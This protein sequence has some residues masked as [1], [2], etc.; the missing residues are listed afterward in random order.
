MATK[1]VTVRLLSGPSVLKEGIV[2]GPPPPPLR[3]LSS[4]TISAEAIAKHPES[5][6]GQAIEA[7]GESADGI[8]EFSRKGGTTISVW[9]RK[10][11]LF[12]LAVQVHIAGSLEGLNVAP[13]GFT[14][15]EVVEELHGY[16]NLP[17]QLAQLRAALVP[18]TAHHMRLLA[19]DAAAQIWQ[20]MQGDV[21]G[22]LASNPTALLG[23]G[24]AVFALEHMGPLQLAAATVSLVSIQDAYLVARITQQWE[25]AAKEG[26]LELDWDKPK[27]TG[28][29]AL[30][31]V[32]HWPGVGVDQW[33]G[34]T[35]IPWLELE[36]LFTEVASPL[37]GSVWGQLKRL[38]AEAAGYG[39][40]AVTLTLRR[41]QLPKR[42]RRELGLSLEDE[43]GWQKWGEADADDDWEGEYDSEDERCMGYA[44]VYTERYTRPAW[45]EEEE[46]QEEPR[47][48]YA[49]ALRRVLPLIVLTF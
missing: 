13:D 27:G 31:P 33:N 49:K 23:P 48:R 6:L 17:Y 32:V 42:E 20:K 4:C 22:M 11:A 16:W 41:T 46:E 18:S 8:Y 40:H 7:Q 2:G 38:M 37:P 14:L 39:L 47:R 44:G 10:P 15:E 36:G 29:Q 28:G 1:A 25:A 21:A 12:E 35:T 34:G 24:L 43:Q 30:P 9:D 5:L 26:A 19:A 45:L 3:V